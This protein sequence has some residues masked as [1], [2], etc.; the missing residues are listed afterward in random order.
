MNKI[1]LTIA[2]FTL[3]ACGFQLKGAPPL[4]ALSVQNWQVSG[5]ALQ[6]PLETAMR[7]A[8]GRSLEFSGSP[9]AEIRVLSV[10][11][12]KDVYTITRAAKLNEYL[13]SMR[14]QAQAFRHGK[15]WGKPMQIDV[16]R[17]MP[18][19]DSMVLGKIEEESTIWQEMQQDAAEQIVR[20]LAFLPDYPSTTVQPSWQY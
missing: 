7:Y 15:E 5:A 16:R 11:T 20:R 10:D 6:Q 19:A 9:E 2:L 8:L 17:T 14:V 1:I 3:C 4:Q 18:Y 13:L 12:K